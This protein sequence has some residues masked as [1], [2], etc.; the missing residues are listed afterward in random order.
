MSKDEKPRIGVEEEVHIQTSYAEL[1]VI[2][3]PT[4]RAAFEL[5]RPVKDYYSIELQDDNDDS[6]PQRVSDGGSTATVS[7]TPELPEYP[8]DHENPFHLQWAYEAADGVIGQTADYFDVSKTT[9]RQNLTAAGIHDPEAVNGPSGYRDRETLLETFEETGRDISATAEGFDVAE[10]TIRNWL[11]RHDIETEPGYQDPEELEA[12]YERNDRVV[13]DTAAAFEASPTTI[14]RW[15]RRFD[16]LDGDVSE[17]PEAETGDEEE[18]PASESDDGQDIACDDPDCE[19]TFDSERGK[20]IHYARTHESSDEDDSPGPVDPPEE[21]ELDAEPAEANQFDF[22]ESDIGPVDTSDFGHAYTTGTIA[23]VIA[24]NDSFYDIGD[25]LKVS[26]SDAHRLC[27]R[28]GIADRIASGQAVEEAE[29]RERLEVAEE[30]VMADGGVAVASPSDGVGV[31][32]D[33]VG[34]PPR[35]I[36]GIWELIDRMAAC[37]TVEGWSYLLNDYIQW[38]NNTKVHKSVAVFNM[39]AATDCVNRWSERCQVDGDECYAVVDEKRYDY[40]KAYMRRQEY[41]WDCL[42]ADTWADAFL[43]IVDRKYSDVTAVKFSQA[44]DFRSDSDIIK[45]DRIAERLKEEGI[46]V[47]TYSASSHLNWSLAEHFTVNQSNSDWEYGDRRYRAVESG[48]EITEDELHCPFDYAKRQG[49]SKD[50]RP[51]CGECRLCIDPD[52]PDV[53][54]IK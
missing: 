14:R 35:E 38:G 15:L 36:D 23:A 7:Q 47:F 52:G 9:V 32:D 3:E 39:N 17:E 27:E 2:D 21:D 30:K 25:E 51:Q 42:D 12:V 49:L 1:E 43:E 37:E 18:P 34:P 45:V 50:E 41:L 8:L 4:A 28:I 5:L 40:V 31:P 53:A 48:D 11:H 16:L 19:R 22:D 6:T 24:R 29:A 54:V 33:R 10:K 13:E 46:P 26:R 44:G 20:N